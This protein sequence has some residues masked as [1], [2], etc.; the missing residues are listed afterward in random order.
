MTRW[1]KQETHTGSLDHPL[2]PDANVP[3]EATLAAA[4]ARLDA[5]QP[6][7]YART[8]NTLNG[9]VSGL[10]PYITHG[11]LGLD[12]VLRVVNARHPLPMQHKFVYELGWRA[13][14]RHVWLHRGAEILHDLHAGPLPV[15]AYQS[16][17]EPHLLPWQANFAHCV[18]APELFPPVQKPCVSFSRWWREASAGF[19]CASDLLA[20]RA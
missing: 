10:S 2:A 16:I 1:H 5:F 4:Y 18:A 20:S 14:F 3:L 8:R 12:D 6:D 17:A 15:A 11:L 9:H 19:A 13:Y 7:A